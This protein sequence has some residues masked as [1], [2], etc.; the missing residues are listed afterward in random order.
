LIL[1]SRTGVTKSRPRLLPLS[2]AFSVCCIAYG[3]SCRSAQGPGRAVLGGRHYALSAM[4]WT[5][6]DGCL[7][8]NASETCLERSGTTASESERPPSATTIQFSTIVHLARSFFA[9]RTSPLPLDLRHKTTA[10]KSRTFPP[11]QSL[12]LV[13]RPPLHS[14]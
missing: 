12:A 5:T 10:R 7:V 1:T 6:R 11:S 9:S 3:C 2:N 14:Y 8:R 4:V 13:L